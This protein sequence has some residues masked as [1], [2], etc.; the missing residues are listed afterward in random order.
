MKFSVALLSTRAFFLAILHEDSKHIGTLIKFQVIK[1]TWLLMACTVMPFLTVRYD[2]TGLLLTDT[3]QYHL[4]DTM[5]K[6]DVA[7]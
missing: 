2:W 5:T 6:H 7:A 3:Y 1:Y 4:R